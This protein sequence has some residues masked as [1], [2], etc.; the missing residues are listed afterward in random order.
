[1]ISVQWLCV[2]SWAQGCG[3]R[4]TDHRARPRLA[5]SDQNWIGELKFSDAGFCQ[6]DH[7]S[8]Q[9]GPVWS[10]HSKQQRAAEL[11]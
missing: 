3:A 6:V 11:D 10:A 2:G 9:C 4:G 1:M 8:V 7:E 5:W